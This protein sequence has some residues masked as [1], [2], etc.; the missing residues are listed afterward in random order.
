M[1]KIKNFFWV[2]QLNAS[3][4]PLSVYLDTYLDSL[5]GKLRSLDLGNY[6]TF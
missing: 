6:K 4:V 3:Q 5:Y 2:H 1:Y